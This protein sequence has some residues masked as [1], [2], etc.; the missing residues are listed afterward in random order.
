MRGRRCELRS[1]MNVRDMDDRAS[2]MLV[3]GAGSG[4]W[5]FEGWIG[6]FPGMMVVAVDLHEGLDIVRSSMQDFAR[7]LI[8]AATRMPAP[9]FVCGWSMGGLVALMASASLELAGLI[10]LEPSPPAELQGIDVSHELRQGG[11]D[12]EEVYGPFPLGIQSRLESQ[13]ARDERKRGISIPSI[14]C[15]CLVVWG[16]EFPNERGR[17]VAD[18]YST[19]ALSFPGAGHWDLVLNADVRDAVRRWIAGLRA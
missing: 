1:S 14:S 11:F 4:P 6:A 2:V 10:L 16:D 12:P 19:E 8:E 17:G 13:L 5:V 7:S 9:L 15:R 3:H 18:L